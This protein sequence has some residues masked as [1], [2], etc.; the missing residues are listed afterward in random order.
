MKFWDELPL[1]QVTPSKLRDWISALGV[2]PKRARNLLTPLR[3]VFEDAL[4]D[5]LIDYNPFDRIA[6]G[7]LLRQTTKASDYEV[8]PFASKERATLLEHARAD[9]RP[10]LQFWFNTGL[11]PGELMALRWAKIDWVG[12]KARIDRNLVAK[13]EKGPK[14][15]A[16]IRDVELNDEAIAALIAQKSAT[17]LA[18]EHVWNNPRTSAAWETDAQIRK[19]LWEPLCTRSG[20]RYRNPYQVRHTFAS[21]L[22]TAG[23]NPWYVAQQLGHVDVQ[24]VFRVYGKFISQDYQRPQA[25]RLRIAIEGQV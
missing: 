8:D 25:A 15:A 17:F 19:T 10:M 12:R 5:E 2:T 21:A 7:K 6:L 16:G 22:L 3:S 13:T 11:R 4:N 20:V 1:G 24:L 23:A 14:T 18:G 9:E